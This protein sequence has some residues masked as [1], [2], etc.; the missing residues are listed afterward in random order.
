[1]AGDAVRLAQNVDGVA[2]EKRNDL[3]VQLVGGAAVE[4]EIARS[5]HDVG[6]TG[7]DRLAGVP[8]FD[9]CQLFEVLLDQAPPALQDAAALRSGRL[10]PRAVQRRLGSAYR[11]I[12]ILGAAIGDVGKGLPVA[13]ID[14]RDAATLGGLQPF[15]IDQQG[16]RFE[17][18][19]GHGVTPGRRLWGLASGQ[20]TSMVGGCA[21]D[22][23]R[24]SGKRVS[25]MAKTPVAIRQRE[26]VKPVHGR[27]RL[28]SVTCRVL[29]LR[30][31]SARP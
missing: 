16:V 29:R 30:A 2:V 28:V 26:V 25:P 18:H 9:L 5:G 3:A 21:T 27:G 11:A 7:R 14:H 24:Q 13:G 19:V 17:F 23:N 6:A 4:L 31:P 1:M 22:E 20:N 10:A 8:G 12:D 15:A